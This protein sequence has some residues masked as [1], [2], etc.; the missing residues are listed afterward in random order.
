LENMGVWDVVDQEDR[1]SVIPMTWAFR[2]KWLPSR[3]I[4]KLK[5]RLCIQGDKEIE[6]LHYWETYAP[7]VSWTIVQLLLILAAELE[8]ATRQVDYTAA[9]VHADVDTPPGFD[10]MSP[11]NQY[12]YSQFAE[13]HCGFAEPGKVL[14]LKKNLYGKIAA[15]RLWFKHLRERLVATGFQQM[16][17]VNPCLFILDKVFCLVY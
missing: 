14:R 17:D 5:T 9:F 2:I 13:M 16:I 3:E 15:P 1:M 11:E 6:N 10:K 4:K 7:V 8:L 12:R